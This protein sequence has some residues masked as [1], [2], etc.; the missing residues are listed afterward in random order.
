VDFA[1]YR[2]YIPGD[3]IRRIVERVWPVRR[4]V[5]KLL[6]RDEYARSHSSRRQ[7]FDELWIG[8]GQKVDMRESSRCLSFFS[9]H[10]HDGVGPLTGYRWPIRIPNERRSGQLNNILAES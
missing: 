5:L 4:V 10:Q 1:E 8:P 6:K 9:Y 2:Q 3:D 7:R